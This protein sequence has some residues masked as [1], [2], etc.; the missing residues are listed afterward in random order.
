M[1]SLLRGFG[2]CC[3]WLSAGLLVLQGCAT[4]HLESVPE[5]RSHQQINRL[6]P[7][8]GELSAQSLRVF[9]LNMAHGRGE[10]FHQLL[11]PTSTTLSNL[12]AIA[13]MVQDRDPHVIA[14]QEADGP[15]FW[16]G[17]FD[18][19]RYLADK[20]NFNQSVQGAHVEGVGLSYGTALV[21][22]L[23]L[24]DP[25]AV[26]F[27]PDQSLVAKGFLMATVSWPGVPEFE[28]DIVSVHLDFASESTRRKQ[29]QQLI[30]VLQERNRPLVMMGD[31]NSEWREDSVLQQ[32][33]QALGLSAYQPQ[34]KGLETFP[35]FDARL[36]WI[37]I[38]AGIRFRSHQVLRDPV[39]DHY[40][41]MAELELERSA[42]TQLP[43]NRSI[44]AT[45]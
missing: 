9:T 32:I 19:I 29:A 10:S 24:R 44:S 37:L 39:S 40:A 26:T 28:I 20:T 14:L 42:V 23:K 2:S 15:S 12:N 3:W 1:T 18:H 17:N 34:G 27:D 8:T 7:A 5:V 22:N 33:G 6:K 4:A 35:A 11:Q 21:S 45:R 30:D 36:D 38:S 43:R 16:S 13:A 41:V 25:K 31:F